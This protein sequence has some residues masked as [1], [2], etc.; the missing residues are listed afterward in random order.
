MSAASPKALRNG[1]ERSLL[2]TPGDRARG[3]GSFF[4]RCSSLPVRTHAPSA[5][6]PSKQRN[7]GRTYGKT[8]TGQTPYRN[9]SRLL[10]ISASTCMHASRRSADMEL[11][12]LF[13]M[14]T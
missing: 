9:L 11:N 2:L 7:A 3:L 14:V 5:H 12:S 8:P 1:I 4:A 13:S 10:S 6:E